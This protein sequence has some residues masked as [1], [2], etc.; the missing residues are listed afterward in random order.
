MNTAKTRRLAAL[1]ATAAIAAGCEAGDRQANTTPQVAQRANTTPQVAQPAS[2]HPSTVGANSAHAP[3]RV[4]QH[5][6]S[7][8]SAGSDSHAGGGSSTTS[9]AQALTRGGPPA[10]SHSKPP[11]IA[12]G[13]LLRTLSGTDNAAIGALTEKTGVVL[14]W[15][16]AS[17]PIQIFNGHGFLLVISN[18]PTGKVKLAKGHYENLHVSA[19]GAWTIQVHA[20]A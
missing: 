15:R 9:G 18:L 6:S 17:P 10:V 13:P 16:T 11:V 12:A 7:R 3:G 5:A 8:S 4:D 1:I 14:E 20:S 2:G 19:K